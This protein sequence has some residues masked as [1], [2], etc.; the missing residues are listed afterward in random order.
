MS[1]LIYLAGGITGLTKEEMS[2]WRTTIKGM[3]EDLTSG[4]WKCVD[5]TQHIPTIVNR[6]VEKECMEWDIWKVKHSDIVVCDFDHPNSI[7]TT[8]ELA[9][10][11]ECGIPI[12]GVRINRYVELHPWWEMS[13]IKI[14]DGLEELYDYLCVN[15]LND[16]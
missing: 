9:V 5:P 7:G 3:I 15:F 14:C 12:V 6:Q 13:A 1:K 11:R 4:R 10:A 16:D 8:W 2:D